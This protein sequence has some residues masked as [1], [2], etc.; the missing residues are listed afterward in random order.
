MQTTNETRWWMCA[1]AGGSSR[2]RRETRTLDRLRPE[3]Q[4][5]NHRSE[6]EVPARKNQGLGFRRVEADENG[7]G[8]GGGVRVFS[9]FVL[10]DGMAI[11]FGFGFS[12]FIDLTGEKPT[13]MVQGTV[14]TLGSS[15]P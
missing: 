7:A 3:P 9:I 1:D 14:A 11:G 15:P 2:S 6:M 5:A 13:G 4:M 12:H 8:E 10:T